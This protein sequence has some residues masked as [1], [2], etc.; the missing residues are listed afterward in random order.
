MSPEKKAVIDQFGKAIARQL[1]AR[2]AHQDMTQNDLAQA[3]GIS[4]SQISKQLRDIRSINMDELA[5]TC[6]AL[7][8]STIEIIRLAE[9]E[10]TPDFERPTSN[11][12]SI[13]APAVRGLSDDE[14]NDAINEEMGQ[15]GCLGEMCLCWSRHGG[16]GGHSGL[17]G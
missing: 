13:H 6:S 14:I 9:R 7:N 17:N 1:N 3:T 16:H 5:L 12:R 15:A 11:V 4:Q 2:R 8:I 10:I